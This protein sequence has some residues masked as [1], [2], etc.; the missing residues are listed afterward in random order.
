MTPPML[1]IPELAQ[2]FPALI[3]WEAA[4][5]AEGYTLSRREVY[6]EPQPLMWDSFD[7]QGFTWDSFANQ[8]ITFDEL[9]QSLTQPLTELYTGAETQHKDI[10]PKRALAVVYHALSRGGGASSLWTSTGLVSVE[11]K[12]W[13][14]VLGGED[15]YLGGRWDSLYQE[16]AVEYA[17]PPE[18]APPRSTVAV[19]VY[20]DGE[21]LQ[22]WQKVELGQPQLIELN[23]EQITAMLWDTMHELTITAID[24]DGFE[25]LPRTYTFKAVEDLPGSATYYVFRDG[26]P[27]AKVRDAREW[28]DYMEVGEHRYMVRAVDRYDNF[29]DSNT[30]TVAIALKDATLALASAPGDYREI[31]LRV[32]ER[33]KKAQE[34]A[35]PAEEVYY[36][37]REHPVFHTDVRR[38]NQQDITFTT[39]RTD[40]WLRLRDMIS[41]GAPVIYRDHYSTRMIGFIPARSTEFLRERPKLGALINHSLSINEIDYREEVDYD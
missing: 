5:E 23:Y 38:A 21:E 27:V 19:T 35:V 2:G 8:A 30:I 41:Q 16:F 36:E 34:Y 31:A 14:P 37:G 40:E 1:Q 22:T 10:V 28:A 13:R 17:I 15:K 6:G 18:A 4:P 11:A 32:N 26:V 29:A 12:D 33:P 25:A 3:A 7:A 9:E 39:R 20:L 24:S